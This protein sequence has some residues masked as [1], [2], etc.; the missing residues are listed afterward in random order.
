MI[1]SLDEIEKYVKSH[2]MP[3]EMVWAILRLT[4]Q[5]KAKDRSFIYHVGL[6]DEAQKTLEKGDFRKTA[7]ALGRLRES[8]IHAQKERD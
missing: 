4:N 3:A 7:Y 8:L 5:A 2:I 1:A 6:V